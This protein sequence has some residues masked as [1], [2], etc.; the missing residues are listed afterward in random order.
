MVSFKVGLQGG[1]KALCM[2]EEELM[3]A[4]L[5]MERRKRWDSVYALKAY[6]LLYITR[7]WTYESSM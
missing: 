1:L 6:R 5:A 4:V 2:M 7:N 3:A